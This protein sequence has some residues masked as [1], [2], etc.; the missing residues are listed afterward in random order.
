M[1]IT[2]HNDLIQGSEAWHAARCGLLT[3]SEM[4]LII[5]PTFKTASNDNERKHLYE[6]L[7]QRVTG[8]VEPQYVSSDMLRGHE[9][10]IYARALYHEKYA[11]VVEAGFITNDEWGFPIGY[12]PDGLVREVGQIEIKSPRQKTHIQTIVENEMPK[13]HIIQ[14]QT[15]LMVTGRS[16]CDYV[17][18]CG[19]LPM[20]VKRVMADFDIQKAILDAAKAFEL[21]LALNLGAYQSLS[22]NLHPTERVIEKEITV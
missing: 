13:E 11:P 10:E 15:G 1:T 8:Y 5:T 16:W 3:A 6:L 7:A 9:S 12:S 22:K 2:Y 4:H 17:S 21:K 18:Y 14:V 19:G 20:F